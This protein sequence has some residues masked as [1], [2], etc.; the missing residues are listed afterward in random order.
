MVLSAS[1]VSL[2][3][4]TM[5]VLMVAAMLYLVWGALGSDIHSPSPDDGDRPELGDA[6]EAET[7]DASGE[8]TEGSSA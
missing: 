2:V 3:S 7:D 5:T 4:V 6:E 1:A 8:L